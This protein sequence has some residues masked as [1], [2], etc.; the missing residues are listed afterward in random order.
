MPFWQLLPLDSTSDHW[1]ASTYQGEVIVRAASEAEARSTATATFFTA[2]AR[3]PG[4]T[5][6]FSP[7]GQASLVGCQRVEPVPYDDQG[8]AAV[9]Y[10][11][12]DDD[13]TR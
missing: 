2:Y 8:P 3:T 13:G 6:L 1:R 11:F 12:P 5:M 9:V 4:D 10:P 7:W